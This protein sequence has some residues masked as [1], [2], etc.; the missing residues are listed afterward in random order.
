MRHAKSRV[1]CTNWVTTTQGKYTHPFTCNS[2][3]PTMLCKTIQEQSCPWTCLPPGDSSWIWLSQKWVFA[4]WWSIHQSAPWL[5]HPST[6]AL[7]RGP[8]GKNAIGLVSYCVVLHLDDLPLF[9][10]AVQPQLL[11]EA[12]KASNLS[13]PFLWLTESKRFGRHGL[14][15]WH[16]WLPHLSGN[17]LAPTTVTGSV[18]LSLGKSTCASWE[19]S[20]K[21]PLHT[22][23]SNPD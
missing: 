18:A 19:V 23:C 9:A 7:W 11:S 2:S 5:C 14:V 13:R 16:Q 3:T 1:Q 10:L 4:T 15:W 22:P 6:F 20:F 8:R 12:F 21:I 17:G